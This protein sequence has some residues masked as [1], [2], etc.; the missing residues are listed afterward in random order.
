MKKTDSVKKYREMDARD[1]K[2]RYDELTR[3]LFN[4]RFQTATAQLSSPARF[5]QVRR[6]ISRIKTI[7]NERNLEII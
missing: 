5:K 3:E 1:L 4:L 7:A 2:E 6:E